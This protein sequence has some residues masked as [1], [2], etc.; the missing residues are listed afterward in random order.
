MP[1]KSFTT[2]LDEQLLKEL[3]KLAIDL[4]CDVNDLLEKAIMQ[5]LKEHGK[6]PKK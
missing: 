2:R 1:R 3:K 4:D 6:A 5:I